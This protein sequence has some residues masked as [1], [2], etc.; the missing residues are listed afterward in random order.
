MV[1]ALCSHL[2]LGLVRRLGR[3]RVCLDLER[4]GP[5]AVRHDTRLLAHRPG[6]PSGKPLARLSGAAAA[7]GG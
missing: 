3:G 4:R 6:R 2:G 5:A 7:T 1:T